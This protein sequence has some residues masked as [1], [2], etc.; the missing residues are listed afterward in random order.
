VVELVVIVVF[1]AVIFESPK[2]RQLFRLYFLTFPFW[3]SADPLFD[4]AQGR[5]FGDDNQKGEDKPRGTTKKRQ[6]QL[7]R[8]VRV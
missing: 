1:C 2:T 4:V 3:E 5:L 6:K 7:Q 8:R